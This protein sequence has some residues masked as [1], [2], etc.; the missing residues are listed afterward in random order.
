MPDIPNREEL[1]RE[2]AKK[3]ARLFSGFSGHLLEILEGRN[4]QDIPESVWAQLTREERAILLPF[5]EKLALASADLLMTEIPMG[6]SWELVNEAAA[7]WARNYSTLLVGQI[8]KTSRGMIATQIRNSIAAF[9]E[10]GLTWGELVRRLQDDP[11][12]SK[13]FGKDVRDRLGRVFG[14][15]RA[16]MIAVTEVTRAAAEGELITVSQLNRDGIAM[17]A[18]WNTRND[19]LVCPKC[20]PLNQVYATRYDADRRPYWTHPTTGVE[21]GPP[22][23]HP[24]CRCT[25]SWEL[26]KL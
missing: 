22:P 2:L 18:K 9:F 21:N 20:G 17:I 4:F 12:L 23:R 6:I 13:L 16:E 25:K 5:L 15:T 14:P 26:P 11:A 7:N 10:E 24:R 8:D 1:E 3:L 19:E